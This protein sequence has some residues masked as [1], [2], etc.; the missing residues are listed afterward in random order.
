MI[1]EMKWIFAQKHLKYA[2]Y[3]ICDRIIDDIVSCVKEKFTEF[4]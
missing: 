3:S 1:G 4:I 2:K